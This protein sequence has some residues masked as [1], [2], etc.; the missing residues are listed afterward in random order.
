[1]IEPGRCLHIPQ[2]RFKPVCGR[3]ARSP[4]FVKLQE[5]NGTK[6]FGMW[7]HKLSVLMEG[8]Q[9]YNKI[10]HGA[11]VHIRHPISGQYALSPQLSS[12]ISPSE[13]NEALLAWS[14]KWSLCITNPSYLI[15]KE[16]SSL[17]APPQGVEQ[18]TWSLQCLCVVTIVRTVGLL[19]GWL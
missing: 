7:E 5:M 2:S 8:S 10:H 9:Y 6:L 16:D 19:F 11:T 3:D 14:S 17:V 1:M 18:L 15:L 4:E 13:I 12:Q